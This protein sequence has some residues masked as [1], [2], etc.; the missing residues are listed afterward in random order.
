MTEAPQ[1]KVVS[2]NL[3]N[4]YPHAYLQEQVIWARCRFPAVLRTPVPSPGQRVWYRH[5]HAGPWTEAEIESVDLENRQDW[6]V[7]RFAV[8]PATGRPVVV[9]GQRVMEMVDDPWPDCV[10]RTDW[11][12]VACRESRLTDSCGWKPKMEK[13]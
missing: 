2:H 3:A 13:D 9:G 7:W 5:D 8:D 6:N 4:P 10:L 1:P 12:R 11:G